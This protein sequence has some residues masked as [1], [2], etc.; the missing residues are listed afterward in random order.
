MNHIEVR[1]YTARDPNYPINQTVIDDDGKG[2]YF[3]LQDSSVIGASPGTWLKANLQIGN[4]TPVLWQVNGAVSWGKP[5]IGIEIKITNSTGHNGYFLLDGLN[6][7][8]QTARA[9]YSQSVVYA[10][11]TKMKIVNETLAAGSSMS[12][13][14]L[15]YLDYVGIQELIRDMTTPI[16]GSLQIP[17]DYTL[18]AGQMVWVLSPAY[19]NIIKQFRIL[20]LKHECSAKGAYTTIYLTDD[21][22]NAYARDPSNLET[23]A[24]KSI[25]PDYQNRDFARIKIQGVSGTTPIAKLINV[26]TL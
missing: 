21:L 8:G 1:L 25:N 19:N 11:G 12:P 10:L 13:T 14:L 20:W 22:F 18:L 23:Q 4:G 9:F 7:N 2:D 3:Y 17:L 5:I 16:T 6:I 15:D 26:D 24:I